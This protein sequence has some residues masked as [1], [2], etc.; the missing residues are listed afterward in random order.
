MTA[1]VAVAGARQLVD[2]P[3]AQAPAALRPVLGRV[4][5]EYRQA[6]QH[7]AD[8]PESMSE[9]GVFLAGQGDLDGAEVA[10]LHARRIA[11]NYLPAMLNLS[12]IYRARNRDDLGEP[13]LHEAMQVYPESGD[14]RH[15]LGLLQVRTGR[16][17]DSVALFRQ[18]AELAPEN[19]Q[20]ALVY[21]VSLVETGRTSEGMAVLEGALRRF[22]G[23]ASLRQA[24]E[25]YRSRQP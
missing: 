16:T 3:L 18:A 13:L 15:M 21:A 1:V 2:L 14:V 19:P 11:P 24:L 6:L 5:D 9:L 25:G 10:L 8:L 23:N 22:P 7:N 20:Y 17:P 12:D 4:F